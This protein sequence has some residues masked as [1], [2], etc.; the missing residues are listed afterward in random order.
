MTN[1]QQSEPGI[2]LLGESWLS[3]GRGRVVM[4]ETARRATM[5]VIA[6]KLAPAEVEVCKARNPWTTP[7]GGQGD[8]RS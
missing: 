6:D 7:Q 3:L 8:E 5:I 2:V 4:T 1:V